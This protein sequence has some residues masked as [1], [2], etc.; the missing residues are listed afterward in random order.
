M[1]KILYGFTLFI[2]FFLSQVLISFEIHGL[3][4]LSTQQQTGQATDQLY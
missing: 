1:E 3:Y 2:D 4:L